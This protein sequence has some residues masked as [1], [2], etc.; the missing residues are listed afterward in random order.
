MDGDTSEDEADYNVCDQ[1]VG[2]IVEPGELLP[3]TLKHWV[4]GHQYARCDSPESDAG[5]EVAYINMIANGPADSALVDYASGSGVV[6]DEI[7]NL[8]L[9]E[10]T[11]V[12]HSQFKSDR[13]KRLEVTQISRTKK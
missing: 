10:H 3:D 1:A 6:V 8:H 13:T 7:H 5:T 9:S 11:T 4:S 2:S 12:A